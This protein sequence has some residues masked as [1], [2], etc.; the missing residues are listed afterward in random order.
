MFCAG[1]TTV[2]KVRPISGQL[3]TLLVLYVNH[4]MAAGLQEG[5]GF[6]ADQDGGGPP[7]SHH[8]CTQIICKCA[9]AGL[10]LKALGLQ[11]P[12]TV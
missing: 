11:L 6:A 12:L 7:R 10:F 5:C 1:L 9:L 4:G 3:V 8:Q 2:C